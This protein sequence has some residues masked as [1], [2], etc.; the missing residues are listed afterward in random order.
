MKQKAE[1][2]KGAIR[3]LIILL[4]QRAIGVGL[5]F[6]AAGTFYDLRGA[7]NLT[8]YLIVSI[9]A[10]VIMFSGHQETLN[11]RSKK[12][13]NTKSWD[14]ILLPVYWLLAYFG[15]YFAAI[16]I[17]VP[18]KCFAI[19]TV[20]RGAPILPAWSDLKH[21]PAKHQHKR[22]KAC[23]VHQADYNDGLAVFI[24]FAAHTQHIENKRTHAGQ[25]RKN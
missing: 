18:A 12:Q 20:S 21:L 25:E 16:C 8:L 19:A 11:E 15:I 6:V 4:L 10:C 3:Y 2:R 22:G 24:R 17:E 14:K 7:A 5:F 9:I 13:E 1:V 23:G